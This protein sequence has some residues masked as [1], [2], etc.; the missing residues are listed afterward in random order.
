MKIL[1]ILGSGRSRG[2]TARI[3]DMVRGAFEARASAE[4]GK[5]E[6]NT[7][8]LSE[9][10][11]NPCRGC[12]VCFDRGE[13]HCPNRDR[14]IETRDAIVEAD[15]VV[16]A[17]PVYVNDVS[18]RMKTL[19]DRLAFVCHRPRFMRT[20]FLL[21]AT[22][23]SSTCR[24]ALRTLQSAAATWSAP[25]AASAGFCT[26]ALADDLTPHTRRVERAASRFYASIREQR[27]RR[28]TFISLMVF[29]IQQRAWRR[30]WTG[31][32]CDTI[33]YHY[34]KDAGWF[35]PGVTFFF[36]HRAPRLRML[37]ARGTALLI[38]R[39]VS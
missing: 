30:Y 1:A 7:L 32:D 22:T 19:I 25:I 37:A 36:P 20:P 39:F 9:L 26:G 33:D 29:A 24:H 38:E 23:G 8:F 13:E 4:D 27:A 3:V 6:W 34:W 35:E 5:M 16:L 12:R 11:L 15:G 21:L 14:L 2:N 10:D 28:P 18:G 31:R 17:S